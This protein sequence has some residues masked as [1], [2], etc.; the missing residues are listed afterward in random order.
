MPAYVITPEMLSK[1][2]DPFGILIQGSFSETINQLKE[3]IKK[4]KPTIIIS[5]GDTVSQNLHQNGI[6][7]QLS[8][9]DNQS[10]RKK[11]PSQIFP[12]KEIIQVR[13][14]QGT[15]T[16]EAT[17]AIKEA[18]QSKK[19]VQI[20]VEGEEDLLTLIAVIYAPKNAL[21]IYGQ[22]YEGIVVVKITPEKK[23]AAKKIWQ[24]MKTIKEE[25][26]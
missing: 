7:P 8:I 23:A 12:N 1:F 18:L 9:V 15:I 25:K 20:I 26:N 24:T 2:K 6:V 16:Q 19:Q 14:P 22:P 3:L 17:D 13:N 4:E 11:V 10:L 21:V 5:V